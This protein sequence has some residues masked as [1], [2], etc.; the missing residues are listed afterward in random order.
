M[1]TYWQIQN[2]RYAIYLILILAFIPLLCSFLIQLA[3]IA[4]IGIVILIPLFLYLLHENISLPGESIDY[5]LSW[6]NGLWVFSNN[7]ICISGMKNK[8]SFSLG[9][10]MHLSIKDRNN[11][12]VDLWLFPDS[13]KKGS[14]GW[15]YLHSCFY[16]SERIQD[17]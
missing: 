10:M 14:Q 3:W 5:M 2:S 1:G 9:F 17:S 13:L 7:E 4:N 11:E 8:S 6:Q 15:H 12:I 16:L